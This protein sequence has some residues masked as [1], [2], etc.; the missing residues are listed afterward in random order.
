M[1]IQIQMGVTS[2]AIP[3]YEVGQVLNWHPDNTYEPSSLVTVVSVN[4]RGYAK[5]SNGWTVDPIDGIAERTARRRGGVVS[6][7]WRDATTA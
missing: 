2:L 1:D 4:S 3:K 5:L 6:A 7:V